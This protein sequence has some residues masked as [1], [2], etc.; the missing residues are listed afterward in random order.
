MTRRPI[1][2]ILAVALL[3]LLVALP[4]LAGQ[5][6]DVPGLER[7][8]AE[9]N[10]ITVSGTVETSTGEDG[11][12]IYVLTDGDTTYELGAGPPWFHGDNHPLAAH[13]GRSVTIDG[14]VAEGSNDIDVDA[15]NGEALRETGPPAW[16]GPPWR[17]GEGHPGWSA[18]KAAWFEAKFG[19]CFP[20]GLCKDKTGDD[21]E[22]ELEDE[23][24][25]K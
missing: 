9:K 3:V 10:P 20:P 5:P 1:M 6:S 22:V 8:K 15:I 21:D 23:S 17:V 2:F 16:A 12:T 25:D 14:E 4:V 18:E 13:V 24:T 11:G 19:D 7:S